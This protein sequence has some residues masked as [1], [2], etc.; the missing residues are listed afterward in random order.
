MERSD[1]VRD[2]AGFE[3]PDVHSSSPE[4]AARF[5]GPTG[6]WLLEIQNRATAALLDDLTFNSVIDVGGGHCQNLPLLLRYCR[7]VTVVGSN[8]VVPD[9]LRPFLQ[10]GH[11]VFKSAHLVQTGLAE[12]S[13]EVVLS[14]RILAHLQDW[15]A[16]VA[17]LCRLANTSVLIDIPVRAGFNTLSNLLFGMKKGVEG[18]TRPYTLFDE[19]EICREFNS[20][21]FRLHSRRAQF[22]WPMALHRLHRSRLVAQLLEA[23]P[24][25]TGMTERLGSSVIARFDR[26]DG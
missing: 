12:R 19:D 3:T 5:S 17:E 26:K 13:F 8:V 24:L 18:N 14:Y 11:V 16:L 9:L 4:Y 20:H 2:G 25:L 22:F 15:Q 1:F 23:L 6:R 10:D 21:G 7:E